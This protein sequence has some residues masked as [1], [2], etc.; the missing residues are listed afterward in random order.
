MKAYGLLALAVVMGLSVT[1][2]P[3]SAQS[4]PDELRHFYHEV[5]GE[6]HDIHEILYHL[7][8]KCEEGDRRACVH[9]GI[10]I[11]ENKERR[12]EWRRE[13]PDAFGWLRP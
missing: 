2:T 8:H 1:G 7:H 13:H 12:E 11:G 9:L 6:H 4:I 10:I 3:A 5:F